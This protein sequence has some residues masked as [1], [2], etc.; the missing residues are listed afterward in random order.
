M[1]S[2]VNCQKNPYDFFSTVSKATIKDGSI[3]VNLYLKR[4]NKFLKNYH[5]ILE[6]LQGVS[7]LF[8][9]NVG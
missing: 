4:L 7:K 5:F 1:W 2:Y 9:H 8:N 6:C 3:R